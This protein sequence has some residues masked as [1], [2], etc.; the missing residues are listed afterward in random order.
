MRDVSTQTSPPPTPTTTSPSMDT[1][2][3]PRTSGAGWPFSLFYTYF[4]IILAP[5]SSEPDL[6][7]DLAPSRCADSPD[8][9]PT[10]F[11]DPDAQPGPSAYR[12]IVLHGP[13]MQPTSVTNEY[14]AYVHVG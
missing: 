14:S 6:D 10:S 1:S 12:W 3:T 5:L 11:F 9:T 7:F 2:I 4:H 13:Y 8:Y